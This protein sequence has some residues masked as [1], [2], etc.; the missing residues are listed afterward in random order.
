VQEAGAAAGWEG[1]TNQ[2]DV[3]ALYGGDDLTAAKSRVE[4]S[5][6]PVRRQAAID[7]YGRAIDRLTA[8]AARRPNDP[9]V[10][11]ALAGAYAGRM[12]AYAAGVAGG[13]QD[14]A[15]VAA[16]ATAVRNLAEKVLASDSGAT[17]RDRLAAWALTLEAL[18]DLQLYGG[19]QTG[20]SA[21]AVQQTIDQATGDAQTAPPADDAEAA[22]MRAI[23]DEVYRYATAIA[24]NPSRAAAAASARAA[25]VGPSAADQALLRTVCGEERDRLAGDALLAAGD[26][27]GAQTQYESALKANPHFAP[28]LIGLSAAH[29]R[30]GDTAGAVAQATAATTAAPNL[31]AAW[32]QLGVAQLA[33]GDA[34][35]RDAALAT[36]FGLVAGE[37]G[38]IATA[39]LRQAIAELGDLLGR[40]PELASS[41]Q[42]V[43][44][45]FRTTLDGTPDDGGYQLASRYAEL[46]HLALMADDAATAEA[47]L[48]RSL[49]LDPHQPIALTDLAT[50]VLAQGHDATAEIHAALDESQDPIWTAAGIAEPVLLDRMRTRVDDYTARFPDRVAAVVPLTDE[51]TAAEAAATLPEGGTPVAEAS[52]APLHATP[53]TTAPLA[54]TPAT[55]TTYESPTFGFS[56]TMTDGWTISQTYSQPGSEGVQVTNGSSFASVFVMTMPGTT[57]AQCLK[58]EQSTLSTQEGVGNMTIMTDANGKGIRGSSADRAFAAFRYPYKQQ[59]GSSV[60]YAFYISCSTYPAPDAM[61]VI[62]QIA[63]A[64]DYDA[65]AASREELVATLKVPKK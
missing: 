52:P 32:R 18:N 5:A 55:P 60:D 1:E 3:T 21:D 14:G 9:T 65:Q 6:D 64:D 46:G 62:E 63:Y 23:Y 26:A 59:D 58:Q 57:P 61:L 22:A 39:D 2:Q 31:P 43:I 38:Q 27:A 28:A 37:P 53:E 8:L 47:L 7:A 45:Q 44:P 12:D 50:A 41:V 13:N 51:I 20:V 24:P 56:L 36:F 33:A 15:L 11:A 10:E 30:Q 48:R 34:A 17:R 25:V 29:E 42:Q 16:D 35:D 19:A 49:D 54:A 4:W 40:R